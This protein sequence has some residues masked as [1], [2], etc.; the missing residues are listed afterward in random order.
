MT[1][2]IGAR[3][4]GLALQAGMV[5]LGLLLPTAMFGSAPAAAHDPARPPYPGWENIKC[6]CRA[7]GRDYELGQRVCLKTPTGLRIAE[8]R[9]SQNVTTWAVQSES[10]DV[11]AE[12]WSSP[13][14][15]K[16]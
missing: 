3:R 2:T 8:C 9:M 7:N 11:N 5:C 12:L 14:P 4:T 1:V 13:I 6:A 16:S 10:C 15:R